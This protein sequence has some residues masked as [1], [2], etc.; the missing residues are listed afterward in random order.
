MKRSLAM[1]AMIC[2]S[3]FT[4]VPGQG[5]EPQDEESRSQR[6][7]RAEKAPR[8]FCEVHE[9]SFEVIEVPIQFGLPIDEPV[10]MAGRERDCRYRF[11]R[12]RD[13]PNAA[14]QSTSGGCTIIEEEKSG[15]SCACRLC[16][17][18]ERKWEWKCSYCLLA[19]N[20]RLWE[21]YD[22][23]QTGVDLF[24]RIQQLRTFDE[25]EVADCLNQVWEQHFGND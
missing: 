15:F 25:T 3:L 24:L 10:S 5:Q 20:R 16:T 17:S 11:A 22:P 4:A 23:D 12:E 2:C 9:V 1:I 19:S 6:Y 13:F 7:C 21:P 8:F 18:S 14:P